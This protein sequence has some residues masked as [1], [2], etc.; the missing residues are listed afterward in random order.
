M[1]NRV[2][3]TVQRA[4]KMRVLDASPE[5]NLTGG[6]LSLTSAVDRRE[7]GWRKEGRIRHASK[8]IS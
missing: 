1:E 8:D 7:D 6:R 3:E 5:E 2:K 4:G